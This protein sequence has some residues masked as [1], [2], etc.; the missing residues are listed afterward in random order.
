MHAYNSSV[1]RT[2]H[3]GFHKALCVLMGWNYWK[4]PD[5]SKLYQSLPADEQAANRDDLIIWP[6]LV[7]VHNTILGKRNDGR[8]DGMGNKDMDAK[9]RG[10]YT[11]FHFCMVQ[12]C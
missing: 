2:D 7:I 1:E 8:M 10:R 3:L 9:I 11:S 12:S 5:D 4:A 6:P